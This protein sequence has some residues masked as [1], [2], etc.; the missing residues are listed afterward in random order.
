MFD[1]RLRHTPTGQR[2]QISDLRD[3]NATPNVQGTDWSSISTHVNSLLGERQSMS[4]KRARWET[5]R[6]WYAI[7]WILTVFFGLAFLTSVPHAVI[8]FPM[9][10]AQDKYLAF[11]NLAGVLLVGLFFSFLCSRLVRIHHGLKKLKA[12]QN[13]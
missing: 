6:G 1:I 2:I 5:S 12:N 13:N 9:N 11:E 4:S 8:V 7:Y 10:Y 3:L